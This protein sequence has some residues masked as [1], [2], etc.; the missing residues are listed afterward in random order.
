[1][2]LHEQR[3]QLGHGVDMGVEP[4]IRET[5]QIIHFTVIGFSIINHPFGIPLFLE[6]PIY[7]LSYLSYGIMTR[8]S[9]TSF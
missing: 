5:P 4:K 2:N 7:V 6:T 8:Y 1:M 9:Y 3:G